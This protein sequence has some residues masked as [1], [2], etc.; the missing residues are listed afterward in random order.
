M[1]FETYEKAQELQAEM[2]YIVELQGL[3][4]NSVSKDHKLATIGDIQYTDALRICVA[5]SKVLQHTIL[6][7]KY[8]KEFLRILNEEYDRIRKEF[9]DL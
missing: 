5:S 6:T 7:E 9:A 3:I 4:Q 1:T 8:A 2:D